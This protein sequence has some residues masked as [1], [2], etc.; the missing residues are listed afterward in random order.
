MEIYLIR[1]TTPDIA[2]DICYGRSNICLT[3]SFAEEAKRVFAKLPDSIDKIYTSPL[4]RCLQLAEGIPHGEL[5]LTPELQ[6]MNFGDWEMKNWSDIPADELNPWMEDFVNQQ[7]P[8]GESMKILAD[9]VLEAYWKILATDDERVVIVT[10]AGPMRII[11]SEVHQ[12]PIVEAFQ[13]YKMEYGEVI[14]LIQ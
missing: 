7:V 4:Q 11:L 9:R 8:N 10:H 13:R 2:K 3:S 12:T 1:H 5:A 14:S 6:E